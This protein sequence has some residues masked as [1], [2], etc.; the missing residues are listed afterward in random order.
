[1]VARSLDTLTAAIDPSS[2]AVTQ[3]PSGE[4]TFV[5]VEADTLVFEK[6]QRRPVAERHTV[7]PGAAFDLGTSAWNASPDGVP[8]RDKK[9][10]VEMKLTLF[11]T[12]RAP[13]RQWAPQEGK[14]RALWS[15]TLRQAEE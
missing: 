14:Y 6:G 5:G 7:V 15:S 1:M 9:Y 11:E 8:L 3:V 4:R 10:V 13:G 12:D 2:L